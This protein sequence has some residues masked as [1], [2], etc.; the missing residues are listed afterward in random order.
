MGVKLG[1]QGYLC[2]WIDAFDTH[3]LHKILRIPYTCYITNV[4]VRAMSGCP[5][6]SNMVTEQCL[7]FCGCTS[8]AVLLMKTIT[9]QLLL[10]FARLHQTGNDLQEDPTT[11]G[12]EPFNWI[13]DSS[14]SYAWKKA[15]SREHRSRRV[16]HEDR[17][18]AERE[19]VFC[20]VGHTQQSSNQHTL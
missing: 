15:A 13:W 19:P 1:P 9:V 5:L 8:H 17:R 12:S 14:P 6:R 3:A 7:R 16:C 11:R 18:E 4:Q 2:A 10:R 20:R